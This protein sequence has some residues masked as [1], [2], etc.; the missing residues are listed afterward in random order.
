MKKSL[1]IVLLVIVNI[2]SFSQE[3][4]ATKSSLFKY[5]WLNERIPL[6]TLVSYQGDTTILFNSNKQY[7]I[8]FWYV[9]CPPCIAEIQWLNKLKEDFSNEDIEFIA[10]SFDSKEDIKEILKTHPFNFKL[11]HL[12]QEIINKNSLALGY[13]TN[14]IV[15]KEGV[16][17][18]QKSGGSSD[19]EKAKE[20]Y[21]LLSS[22][23]KKK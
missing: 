19:P 11:Y 5:K 16:V 22:E 4:N 23:L 12:S 20:I 2:I 3:T 1:I 6:D 10:I 8:S 18:F 15:N 21:N 13:P 14:L 17:T 7:V 9:S